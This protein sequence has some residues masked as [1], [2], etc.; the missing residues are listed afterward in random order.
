[1]GNDLLHL[2]FEVGERVLLQRNCEL[3]L[4]EN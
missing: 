1:M 2:Q 4:K 3:L